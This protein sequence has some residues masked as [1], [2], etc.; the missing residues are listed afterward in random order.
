MKTDQVL[1]EITK[2]EFEKC[3]KTAYVITDILHKHH[4][5]SIAMALQ[6][7]LLVTDSLRV[8]YEFQKEVYRK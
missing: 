7:S 4:G 8:E 5:A 1:P 6:A 2:D 3:K